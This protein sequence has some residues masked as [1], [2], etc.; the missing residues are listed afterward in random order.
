M[1][2]EQLLRFGP[3]RLDPRTTQLWRGTLE[4]SL[5]PKALSVL[6]VLVTQPGQVVTKEEFFQ[7]VWGETV[8]SDDALA[9][10]IQELRRALQDD[11]RNP[12]YIETA[13][14]RGYRFIGKVVSDPLSVVSQA[15]GTRGQ[16]D[17]ENQKAKGENQK[18]SN[19]NGLASSVQSLESATHLSSPPL[20][21]TPD[22]QPPPPTRRFWSRGSFVLIGLVLL[23]GTIVTIQY[24]S[25]PVPSPS[26]LASNPQLALP[27]PDKPSLAVLPF[28]NMSNDPAQD[29]LGDGM[30][31][32]LTVRLG[33]LSGLFVISRNS[34]FTYKGKAI[35]MSDLSQ[36]LGVRYVLEGSVRK[37]DSQVRIAVQLIDATQDLHLW[38]ESYDRPLQ[39]IFSLQ[40]EIAEK[41]VTTLK[42]QLTL[43]EQGLPERKST[44]NLEAYDY[45]LR[46]LTDLY[47]YTKEANIRARQMEEKATTL[48]PEYAEA[49]AVLS[50]TYFIEWAWQWTQDPQ[51]LEQALLLA[52]KALTL[53]DF[54]PKA[55][56]ALAV[57]YMVKQQREEAM[58][59]VE[60][61]LTL[62]PNDADLHRVRGEILARAGRIE[63]AI[64]AIQQAIRLNPHAPAIY[65]YILGRNYRVLE[66]YDEALAT[67]KKALV[68]DPDFL[69][70]HL[71]LAG[72][73][74][75][76]GREDEA[77]AEVA[78]VLRLNP[79]FSLEVLKQD[80]LIQDPARRERALAAL[81]K[82]G[83]K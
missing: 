81:R 24:L 62:S 73:Y 58:A 14:R 65:L 37:A 3:Y 27:L 77:R 21:Q 19:E 46:G 72:L 18:A 5:T 82:A 63:D 66:R 50:L 48:D 38:S 9:A 42:L 69:W 35:K 61:A 41:I 36:E 55:H 13:H 52:Q 23:I 70:T 16:A 30:T 25:L 57:I 54:S 32:E 2:A 31:E 11:A 43:W 60:R 80:S 51:A 7:S 47:R 20:I 44:N 26:P 45:Y 33:R 59:A 49:Y 79:N 8:V 34:A 56:H 76:L 29:Y 28:V 1:Q 10:C 67:F 83:L 78:E 12:R 39:D 4:V 53:D 75:E 17:E 68:R 40:Q 15:E 6:R 71:G 64:A 22:V 74:G